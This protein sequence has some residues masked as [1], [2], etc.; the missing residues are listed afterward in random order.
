MAN[1][2]E[3]IDRLTE[4]AGV[5]NP[6]NQCDV[7]E[8]TRFIPRF[9]T[10]AWRVIALQILTYF[11]MGVAAFFLMGYAQLFENTELRHLMRPT[12]SPWV[13]IGPALQVLRG[14]LFA[15]VLY[16]FASEFIY[17]KRGALLLWS[18]FVG[19]AILG[20]AGPSPGSLEGMIYTKVQFIHHLQGL[21]E[22]LLQTLLFSLGLTWW[23]RKPARWKNV[24]SIVAVTLIV[25]MSILGVFAAMGMLPAAS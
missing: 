17:R 5:S 4:R 2:N 19:L 10:F 24:V 13:A 22:V 11:F 12:T 21:P 14:M 8:G 20:T 9:A 25:L 3:T 6:E 23:C 15:V 16:P 1:P 7:A 18:L